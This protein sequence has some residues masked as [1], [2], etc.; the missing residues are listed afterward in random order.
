LAR[1]GGDSRDP[2]L[3][4]IN[5]RDWEE[6]H[7]HINPVSPDV[8][9]LGTVVIGMMPPY[10]NRLRRNDNNNNNDGLARY[11]ATGMAPPPPNLVVVVVVVVVDW[12]EES[13]GKEGRSIVLL[14]VQQHLAHTGNITTF[15]FCR[16]LCALACFEK[17]V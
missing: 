16:L 8:K 1:V 13:G 2:N 9:G 17:R 15:H 4:A 5:S 14:S 11:L 3:S 7:C 12:Q 6:Q 10:N